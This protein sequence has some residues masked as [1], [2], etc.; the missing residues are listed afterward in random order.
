MPFA[1]AP[2]TKGR[3]AMTIFFPI[4]PTTEE[5]CFVLW[6]PRFSFVPTMMS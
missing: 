6:P 3:V 1:N 5:R 4:F 2:R